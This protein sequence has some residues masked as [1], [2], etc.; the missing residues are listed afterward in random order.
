MTTK[1]GRYL[2]PVGREGA[3]DA[4]MGPNTLRMNVEFS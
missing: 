4:N 3:V 2:R 1:V